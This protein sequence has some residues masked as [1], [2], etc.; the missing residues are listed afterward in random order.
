MALA[1]P[2]Q[3]AKICV[4]NVEMRPNGD[5]RERYLSLGLST[6]ELLGLLYSVMQSIVETVAT[7]ANQ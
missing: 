3:F 6:Y 4:I 2:E 1:H 7:N 5:T